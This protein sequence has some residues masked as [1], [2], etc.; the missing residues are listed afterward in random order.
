MNHKISLVGLKITSEIKKSLQRI[1]QIDFIFNLHPL[2]QRKI[3]NYKKR[4]IIGTAV[5]H[6]SRWGTSSGVFLSTNSGT[7]WTVVGLTNTSVYAL[8]VSGTNLF[9]GTYDSGVW[10][11]A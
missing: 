6:G 11:R 1:D 5:V 10:R 9:A 8:A 7:S 4:I 3:S 2:I